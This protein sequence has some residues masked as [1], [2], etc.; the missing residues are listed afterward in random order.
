MEEATK[1]V[2]QLAWAN[3]QNSG[4]R[5]KQH[6]VHLDYIVSEDGRIFSIRRNIELVHYLTKKGY[7][8]C[9]FYSNKKRCRYRVHRAVMETFTTL[10]PTMQV[11]HKDTNK[12]NNALSNL[13]WAT[14]AENRAHAIVHGLIHLGANHHFAKLTDSDVNT[15]RSLKGTLSRKQVATN[16]NISLSYVSNI[17]NNRVRIT[18]TP[19]ITPTTTTP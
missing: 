8:V 9:V 14:N 13:H 4:V 10:N 15:I 17:W 18:T 12:N 5:L 3:A 2:K 16:Y 7:H 19:T 1:N 11:N 6:P